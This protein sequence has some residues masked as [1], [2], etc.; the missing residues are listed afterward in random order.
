MP[1]LSAEQIQA[2]VQ[3]MTQPQTG[4]DHSSYRGIVLAVE[5]RKVRLR[6]SFFRLS[7]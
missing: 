3:F 4:R 2:G 6:F 1:H 7:D 5:G